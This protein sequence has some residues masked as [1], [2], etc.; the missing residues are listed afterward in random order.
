VSHCIT[1]RPS[2]AIAMAAREELEETR[3]CLCT[4]IDA[5][6]QEKIRSEICSGKIFVRRGDRQSTLRP[7]LS[8]R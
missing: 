5:R 3:D 8:K 6:H 1:L 2:P 4:W 7:S